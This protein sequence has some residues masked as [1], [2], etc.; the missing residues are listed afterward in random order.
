MKIIEIK[1]TDITMEELLKESEKFYIVCRNAEGSKQKYF[2][3]GLF[4]CDIE[5]LSS[6]QKEAKLIR[7][8]D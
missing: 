6:L 8:E 1:W 7:I 2:M 4:S 3:I 5:Q